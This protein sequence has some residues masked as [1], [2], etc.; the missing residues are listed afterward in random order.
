MA[1]SQVRLAAAQRNHIG[2]AVRAFL[3]FE[4]ASLETGLSRFE[5]KM[6]IVR[7]PIK[8]YPANPVYVLQATA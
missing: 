2:L 4:V 8:A 5:E 1:R 6:R 3:R 7:D